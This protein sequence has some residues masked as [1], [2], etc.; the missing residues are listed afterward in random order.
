MHLKMYSF[1]I[2]LKINVFHSVENIF[3]EIKF[4]I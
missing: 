1:P 4:N 2:V 3:S